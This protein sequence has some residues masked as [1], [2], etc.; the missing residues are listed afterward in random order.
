MSGADR[1]AGPRPPESMPENPLADAAP[2]DTRRKSTERPKIPGEPS[3]HATPQARQ[4]RESAFIERLRALATTPAAR[5]LRDDAALLPRPGGDLVL[6]HDMLVAG[7]HFLPDDPPE[8]IAWKLCAVNASDLAAKGATPLG[9]LM[10]CGLTGHALA[11]GPSAGADAWDAAFVAGLAEALAHFALPLLGGDTVSM[12]EG[13]PLT[14]GLT[15]LGAAPACG[16][17]S[18]AGARPGDAL[19]VTGTIGDAGAGLALASGKEGTPGAEAMQGAKTPPRGTPPRGTPLSPAA[20]ADLLDAYRRPRPPVALGPALAPLAS[21][22]ADISDGLLI[23]ADRMAR[24]SG[25]AIRIDL[26][27]VP[28]SAAYVALRGDS[29][30]SRLRAATA[31][32]DYQLLLAAAPET[33]PTLRAEATRAGIRLARIGRCAAGTP[34]LTLEDAGETLPLPATLGYE[35]RR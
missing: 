28:L 1:P 35:H 25:V 26:G 16:A 5:G 12:P 11:T 20:R 18:R 23:D 17:P 14:L 22:M 7:V 27:A 32:D 29:R 3:A 10:G 31:G 15:A 30:A 21:A 24:A 9:A 4:S 6:T 2:S 33:E 34:G 19:F 8:S 13:G